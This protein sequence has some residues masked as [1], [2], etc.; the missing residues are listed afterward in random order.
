LKTKYDSIVK[1]KKE[2]VS[3]IERD[4]QKIN[5][6]ILKIAEKIEDLKE[7]LFKFSFPSS[8][9]FSKIQ[10]AKIAQNALKEEIKTYEN[11]LSMLQSRKKDL[12]EEIKKIIKEMRLKEARDMDEIALL[13]RDRNE[14]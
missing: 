9:T 6:A 10:Q 1:I 14:S 5:N 7:S 2:S 12:L 4:I 11:Q 3:K 13:L 8:G